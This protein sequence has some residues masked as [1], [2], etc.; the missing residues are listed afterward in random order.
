MTKYEAR[1]GVESKLYMDDRGII[2][3]K[4]NANYKIQWSIVDK[5]TWTIGKMGYVSKDLLFR[6]LKREYNLGE[7][8]YFKYSN[9]RND[10]PESFEII[11]IPALFHT[12]S[13][14][15]MVIMAKTTSLRWN[16][17]GEI[18]TKQRTH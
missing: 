10:K 17:H 7:R 11:D 12:I 6:G 2:L 13:S 16:V 5:K 8:I 9:I 4:V 14:R 3:K 18:Y 15:R 1:P